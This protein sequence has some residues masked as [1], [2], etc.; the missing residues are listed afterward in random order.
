MFPSQLTE[1]KNS[2]LPRQSAAWSLGFT[3]ENL[4]VVHFHVVDPEGAV[5]EQLKT[6]VL[7]KEA[8]I[9]RV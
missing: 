4:S 1:H 3:A 5:G 2:S 8:D 9:K 7:E 6:R